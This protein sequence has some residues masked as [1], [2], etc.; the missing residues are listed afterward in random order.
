M[1][2]KVIVIIAMM[3]CISGCKKSADVAAV[4]V[5]GK[6]QSCPQK[7]AIVQVD[8]TDIDPGYFEQFLDT[9]PVPDH[10][11]VDTK[12]IRSRLDELV[13][14]EVLYAE[15]IRLGLDKQPQLRFRIS[16]MLAQ[17]L[18]EEKV[19]KPI[20][21]KEITDKEVQTYYDKHI[22]EFK[23][24]E[25]VRIADI[26]IAVDPKAT[27]KEQ[28]E[29]LQLANNILAQAK[30]T[31]GRIGFGKLI[32]EHS[33]TPTGYEKGNTGYFDITGKPIGID[34]AI[35]T[36]AFKLQK[37]GQVA[38]VVI[39]TADGYHVIMLSR[40]RAAIDTP[41]AKIKSQLT[42]RIRREKLETARKHYIEELKSKANIT[43]NTDMVKTIAKQL[44]EK[45]SKQ[46]KA[47]SGSFPA[48][49]PVAPSKTAMPRGPRA[50]KKK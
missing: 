41:L 21:E 9:R 38:D 16:Q 39:K 22:D 40:R 3:L 49:P 37:I 30:Q 26:Y 18:L 25:Q 36:E 12:M 33:D 29:K 35:V 45:I 48:L 19:N 43:V 5:G 1:W 8:G 32:M 13:T 4:E 14:G 34:T 28:N 42:Q 27:K 47:R 7:Q 46:R 50:N 20:Y 17:V 44:N 10:S 31:T 24:G 6:Q 11:A 2:L 15:A 23:R